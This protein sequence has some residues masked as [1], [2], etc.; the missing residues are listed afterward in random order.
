MG[1]ERA[2]RIEGVEELDPF[3]VARAL[4]DAVADENP[5]LAL[6][7][8]QSSDSVQATTGPALATFLGL[9]SVSV[10]TKLDWDGSGP[11][12]VHRELEGGTVDVLEVDTPTLLTIQ[13]GIN[14]PRYVTLRAIKQAEQ[15]TIEVHQ[16]SERDQSAYRVRR[17]FVPPRGEGAEMLGDDPLV[18]ARRMHELLQ[19]ALK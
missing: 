14:E 5:G 8:A 12:E 1:V 11:A 3:T 7:G 17:M 16:A 13:T 19:E 18:I 9:P 6:C 10:V 15:K 2:V 4:A